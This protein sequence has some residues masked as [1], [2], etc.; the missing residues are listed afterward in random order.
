MAD[1]EAHLKT[2]PKNNQP[3]KRTKLVAQFRKN[4]IF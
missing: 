3:V 2:V 4:K 1:I